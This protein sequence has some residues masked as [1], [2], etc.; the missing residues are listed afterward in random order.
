MLRRGW[1]NSC[2]RVTCS[3]FKSHPRRA[4]PH[5]FPSS[6]CYTLLSF[7]LFCLSV[8]SAISRYF[9][10]TALQSEMR[11]ARLLGRRLELSYARLFLVT[12]VL[13]PYFFFLPTTARVANLKVSLLSSIRLYY[14]GCEN[15]IVKLKATFPSPFTI[16][17]D[18][19]TKSKCHSLNSSDNG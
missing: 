13:S 18:A 19:F 6:R 7:S 3:I 15:L 2:H 17:I 14:I 10:Y 9:C 5:F 11:Q 8:C 4:R 12:P 1:R 16:F